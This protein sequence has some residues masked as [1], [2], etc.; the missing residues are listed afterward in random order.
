MAGVTVAGVLTA[1]SAASAIVSLAMAISMR[2]DGAKDTGANIDRKGADNPKIVPFGNCLVPAVR[3]WNNVNDSNT[4]WLCQAYSLG[5]GEIKAVEQIY[6]DGVPYLE[7]VLQPNAWYDLKASAEFPNVSLGYRTGRAT[8]QVFTELLEHSDGEWTEAHRGDKTASLSMLIE[9]WINTEGDNNIRVVSDTLDVTAM[10]QGNRVIDPRLDP[11]LNGVMFDSSRVWVSNGKD[12]YRNPACVLLTYLV[13]TYYGM[14]IPADA[15]DVKSFVDLANYCERQNIFFDGY[16]DQNQSFG[17][18]LKDMATSFDGVIYVEDGMIRVKADRL[19]S[20]V[21]HVTEADCVGSFKLSNANDSSYFNIV[22]V[23]YTNTATYHATDKYV[24]PVDVLPVHQNDGFE[25][26]KDINLPFTAEVDGASFVKHVANKSLKAVKYQ[27]TIDFELDNTKKT[28]RIWDVFTLDNDA[29]KLKGAMFRVDKVVTSLDDKTMV[30]KVTATQF[31]PSVYDGS[32]YEDGNTSDPTLPPSNQILEPVQLEFV[33]TGFSTT[34][35]GTLSWV[36]RYQREHKTIIEYKLDSAPTWTRV[37]EFQALTHNFVGLLAD[38]YDF[39]IRTQ[40][41]NGST[42]N[43]AYLNDV[44]VTS[45]V[46]MPTVTGLKGTFEGKSARISWDDM[47]QIPLGSS[48]YADVFAHYEVQVYKGQNE[49]YASTY[50]SKDNSF[51]YTLDMN[52]E[53][54]GTDRTLHFKVLM[55]SKDGV[56][57]QDTADLN[58]K[59]AQCAQPSGVDVSGVLST[60]YARWDEVPEIDYLGSE[61]HVSVDPIFTAS[62][63]TLVGI[64]HGEAYP[65]TQSKGNYYLRIGHFDVFGTDEMA[66]SDP[67]FFTQTSVDDELEDLPTFDE[68]H[69]FIGELQG[70]INQA[71]EDMDG[72]INQ[73]E[74][75]LSSELDGV[76]AQVNTNKV[77]IADTNKAMTALETELSSEIDGVSGEVGSVKANLANNYYTKTQTNGQVST[78]I[79]ASESKLT[80]EIDKN[81]ASISTLNQ[82]T[83]TTDGKV[84]ALTQIKHDVNGKVSGLI[85]GNDGE[86]STFDVIADKFRV[87]ST[88]GTQAVFQVVNGKTTIK[89][90][91]IGEL[92]AENI[93]AGAIMGNHVASNTKIIAGQGNTAVIM[94]GQSYTHRL[95][96]GSTNPNSAPFSVTKE[97]KL[98]AQEAEIHGAIYASRGTFSGRIEASEGFFTGQLTGNSIIGGRI[99]GGSIDGSVITGSEIYT[100]TTYYLCMGDNSATRNYPNT[101]VPVSCS[102]NVSNTMTV[103]FPHNGQT[104]DVLPTYYAAGDISVAG[105]YSKE[106]P[107]YKTVAYGFFSM[108]IHRPSTGGSGFLNATI[109][110]VAN[111]GRVISSAQIFD[112]YAG[113]VLNR[114]VM[115]G[116]IPWRVTSCNSNKYHVKDVTITSNKGNF[117][118]WVTDPNAIGR[119]RLRVGSTH[120]GGG[121]VTYRWNFNNSVDPR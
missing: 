85:M 41:F 111:N 105:N 104:P 56:K 121:T 10:V 12:V 14:G 114:D 64:S 80:A 69:G 106:R 84:E 66:Y 98:Y 89:E 118:G 5:V 59:N 34:G 63:E 6:I 117:G 23:E 27:Q 16:V 90:A 88:Q 83:A 38:T 100:G 77:S 102:E 11:N 45:D 28:L 43:W 79:A 72:V 54:G 51:T 99:Q 108:D 67:M 50:T 15:I 36:S 17:D 103:S 29:Y 32:D 46:L 96:A 82:V 116:G 22:K 71:L 62:S 112:S 40:T 35:T 21:A 7:G 33:Q 115:V 48:T 19:T 70:E 65:I 58:L 4:R 119:F 1:L 120:D 42:S 25:K 8:E 91:L 87:A 13:D 9:R 18:A 73:V 93:A 110:Y 109:E 31:E 39:R 60:V 24:L 92:N 30:T 53:D 26:I 68:V 86:T 57:S 78:A 74:S 97:G 2:P 75:S 61:I 95:Y 37:G 52:T 94:D 3:V 81:K 55:V 44:N 101:S 47:T 113:I 76:Q 49:S 20:A 107:R